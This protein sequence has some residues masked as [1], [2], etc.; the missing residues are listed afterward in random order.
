M[1]QQF[2][3][4]ILGKMSH[5][6]N[7]IISI[8]RDDLIAFRLKPLNVL[9]NHESAITYLHI[10]KSRVTKGRVAMAWM[11]HS[12]FLM[13]WILGTAASEPPIIVDSGTSISGEEDEILVTVY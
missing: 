1:V 13:Q 5:G 9:C 7:V 8:R 11:H 10:G 6:K 4:R 2:K 3:S 12:C